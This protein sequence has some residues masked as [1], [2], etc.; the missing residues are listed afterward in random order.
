MSEQETS[1]TTGTA[2][3]EALREEFRAWA[4]PKLAGAAAMLRERGVFAGKG[5]EARVAWTLPHK[6][7]V[8]EIRREDDSR[9]FVWIIAGEDVP[10]DHVEAAVADN[11][12]DVARH[13]ALKWQLEAARLERLKGGGAT[14]ASD[15][16]WSG[17]SEE[18]ARQAEA[19]YRLVD[20]E[21]IWTRNLAPRA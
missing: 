16:N 15:V 19:L 9:D 21:D 18:L 12:R 20:D 7:L 17:V 11:P 13:F 8:G 2:E 14:T 6:L 1:P 5:V 10:T 3:A 4:K